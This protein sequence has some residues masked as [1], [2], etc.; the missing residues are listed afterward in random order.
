MTSKRVDRAVVVPA[1]IHVP[2]A[3]LVAPHVAEFGIE[4]RLA[5]LPPRRFEV[6]LGPRIRA[7]ADS[8]HKRFPTPA[9][10]VLV[11]R[12]EIGFR[13]PTAAAGRVVLDQSGGIE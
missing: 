6:P 13:V 10:Q 1:P 4:H 12:I 11:P 3:A 2:G 8:L 7:V 9:R 5:S